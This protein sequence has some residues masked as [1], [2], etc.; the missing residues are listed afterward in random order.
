MAVG[1]VV[2]KA[3]R[4]IL[5]ELLPVARKL[6]DVQF[7]V[8]NG[9]NLAGG[10]GIT[11][12]LYKYLVEELDVDAITM[13]NHWHDKR[14]IFDFLSQAPRIVLPAN[15]ANVKHEADGIKCLPIRGTNHKVCVINLIG[16]A[17]M[18][19][20]NRCP[21]EALN[22]LMETSAYQQSQIQIVDYHG[23]A[24]SEKQAI[25]YYM[26]ER[27]SLV[28]GTHSHVPTADERIIGGHTG[29]LTDLGMTG[30]YDSIIGME[31]KSA[32]LR[33]MTQDKSHKLE[34]AKRMPWMCFI[35]ADIDVSN[36]QCTR[37]DRYRWD[38]RNLEGN[39]THD[40]N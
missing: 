6:F 3:G 13:G 40:L 2:G 26:K 4:S 29:F 38:E 16:R 9:E 17:F 34:P 15:M 33:L 18:K 7:V 23:E 5:A 21:F 30:A 32:T 27:A 37:I 36:G 12:K 24:T 10:F 35:I 11:E 8:V 19:G 14:E 22:R 31:V 20:E 25:G 39:A 28:Y 1:D